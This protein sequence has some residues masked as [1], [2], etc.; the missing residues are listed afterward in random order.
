MLVNFRM[1]CVSLAVDFP[2]LRLKHRSGST[3][4]SVAPSIA[5]HIRVASQ[6]LQPAT[7]WW[8]RHVSPRGRLC[9]FI[10]YL[11]TLLDDLDASYT[12]LFV[13]LC[14]VHWSTAGSP[15]MSGMCDRL[16]PHR[17]RP[18]VLRLSST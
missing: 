1:M 12:Y 16:L 15:T 4:A 3:R 18:P 6:T 11:V 7:F 8:E 2:S 14:F 10:V 9:I 17:R 5:P 13:P